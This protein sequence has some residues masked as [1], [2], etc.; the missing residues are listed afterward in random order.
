VNAEVEQAVNNRE[1]RMSDG[2]VLKCSVLPEDL[3]QRV[4]DGILSEKAAHRLAT[5]REVLETL[6]TLARS[7]GIEEQLL[8]R[9]AG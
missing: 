1:V 9:L 3:A 8:T 6:W 7:A 4:R 2:R 5:R